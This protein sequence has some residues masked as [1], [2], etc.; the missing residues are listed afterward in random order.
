[1]S[2]QFELRHLKYFLMVAA[3]AHFRKASEKLFITQPGLSRQIKQLETGLGVRLFDRNNRKVRLTPAG[4]YLQREAENIFNQIDLVQ[5][6]ARLISKGDLGEL[7]IGFVGSAVQQVIPSILVKLHEKYPD[8]NT[9]LEEMPNTLQLEALDQE[10]LDVGFVR[11]KQLP[12]G[13]ERKTVLK[14][15]FSVVL[16]KNHRLNAATFKNVGQLSEEHFILFRSDY[17]TDY[18]D[19]VTSICKDQG[20][21]PKVSHRT[22]HASTIFRLVENGLG[23]S[24]I[25]SSLIQG[26]NMQVKALEIKGIPQKAVLS[27]IWKKGST[28]PV[29]Q[30]FLGIVNA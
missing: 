20:F 8:I 7:R 24:I 15:G 6:N 5:R 25:P 28:N 21:M 11:L 10:Q 9:S 19:K 14:E 26:Y 30:N 16:P 18:Y 23:I 1:M 27:M 13:M 2:N 3:E 29:L 4:K 12:S 17:S 22:V